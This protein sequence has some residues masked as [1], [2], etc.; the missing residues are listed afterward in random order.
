M[1]AILISTSSLLWSSSE[2]LVLELITTGWQI[3]LIMRSLNWT[4]GWPRS[5]WPLSTTLC[6]KFVTGLSDHTALLL[7][8]E[9]VGSD[10]RKKY[11][12]F[13][14]DTV[15][16]FGV[17]GKENAIFQPYFHVTMS[18]FKFSYFSNNCP[19]KIKELEQFID[20]WL[21]SKYSII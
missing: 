9:M 21:H 12:K 4:T 3:S 2:H 14:N 1:M 15:N 8:F 6:Y 20:F 10:I 11:W 17:I 13:H 18:R 7:I 19:H 16:T 5:G